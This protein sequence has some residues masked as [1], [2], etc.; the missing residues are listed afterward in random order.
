MN[1]RESSKKIIL[2]VLY[3][4]LSYVMILDFVQRFDDASMVEKCSAK[5][6]VVCKL[7]AVP[8]KLIT[9]K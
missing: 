7:I 9:A 4:L 2:I 3:L 8:K 5:Y 1:N 6:H